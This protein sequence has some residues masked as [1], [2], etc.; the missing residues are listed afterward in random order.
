VDAHPKP[1]PPGPGDPRRRP[2]R[3]LPAAPPISE[4][5]AEPGAPEWAKLAGP[6]L[7]RYLW[8][9]E[10]AAGRRVL[11]VACG[12]GYGA[13][14]LRHAG[15][16]H[17]L[18]VDRDPAAIERARV[19]FGDA[20]I[21]FRCA[22]ALD[23]TGLDG[24]FDLV[25]S[26]ETIE[27]LTGPDAF[28]DEVARVMAP[29]ATVVLSTPH[30]CYS[31][32]PRN[33]RPANLHHVQEWDAREFETLLRA[34]FADVR[35]RAQVRASSVVARERA[36][37]A[38]RALLARPDPLARILRRLRRQDS[39]RAAW[40]ALM[41]LAVATPAEYPVVAPALAPVLGDPVFLIALCREPRGATP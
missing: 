8:A 39:T 16:R 22:D 14:L 7:A 6:H 13:V 10:L 25:V 1:S 24:P 40:Q 20:G 5:R 36:V 30:R 15:A 23:L 27:H 41:G 3:S 34:H 2:E 12:S 19:R 35:L 17:V 4:E 37:S 18:G 9:G 38:L 26:F 32:P 28:L 31:E 21:E 29:G 11:D 33:G